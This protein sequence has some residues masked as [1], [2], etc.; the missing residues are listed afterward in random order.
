M[1]ARGNAVHT[2]IVGAA[3]AFSLLL[4]I[5]CKKDNVLPPSELITPFFGISYADITGEI[6]EPDSDDWKPLS[7]VGMQFTPKGAYPNPCE[8]GI[9]FSLQWHLA[10][11]DSVMITLNDSPDHVVQTVYAKRLAPGNYEI[12]SQA[13]G[14]LPAIY[15]VYF[16][17]VRPES[18]YVTYGDVQV[19]K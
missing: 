19:M 15:R 1:S 5:G 4:C 7:A 3:I 17:I 16:R 9:G 10:A 11:A 18:T 2:W 8:I 13:T 14:L 6:V 12:R